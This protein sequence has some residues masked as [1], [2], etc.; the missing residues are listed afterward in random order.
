MEQL[1]TVTISKCIACGKCELACAFAHARDGI[2][3]KSRI[4]VTR[5]GVEAGTPVVCF[6]CDEAAC[7]TACPVDALVRNV[8]TGAIDVL[9]DRCIGCRMCVAACPF[10]NM[11][12]DERFDSVQKCDLCGG[13]PRCVPFCPTRA[14]D[15]VPIAAMTA[16]NLKKAG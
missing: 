6:Q 16:K 1:F 7:A 2:P 15:Y 14:I 9:Y 10:G 5:R 11:H 12:C 8:S 4:H 13:N 3:A